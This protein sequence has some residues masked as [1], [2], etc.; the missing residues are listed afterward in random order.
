V[1]WSLVLMPGHM[2]GVAGT[3]TR[4]GDVPTTGD[5]GVTTT[6]GGVTTTAGGATTAGPRGL[7]EGYPISPGHALAGL[8]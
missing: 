7:A 3:S 1:R 8:R 2:S 4:A 6:A 5:E